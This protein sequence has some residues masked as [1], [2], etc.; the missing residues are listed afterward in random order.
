MPEDT[1]WEAPEPGRTCKI[2]LQDPSIPPPSAEQALFSS[3]ILGNVNKNF[4]D[5][6]GLGRPLSDLLF[7]PLQMLR[8]RQATAQM[9]K[10]QTSKQG[11]VPSH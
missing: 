10:V 3:L 8:V 7:Q 2:R 1:G 6:A 5:R 9:A 4:Q 11:L